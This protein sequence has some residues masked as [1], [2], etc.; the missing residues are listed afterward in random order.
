VQPNTTGVHGIKAYREDSEK[1]DAGQLGAI[2]G[3]VRSNV[4]VEVVRDSLKVGQS[5]CIKGA[6]GNGCVSLKVVI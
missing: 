5:E 1:E 3:V 2:P 6:A 4:T